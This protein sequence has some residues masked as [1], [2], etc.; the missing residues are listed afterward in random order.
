M[1]QRNL[2]TK[3]QSPDQRLYDINMANDINLSLQI[4]NPDLQKPEVLKSADYQ[5]DINSDHAIKAI[6]YGTLRHDYPLMLMEFER[7]VPEDDDVVIEILYC[8][9]CHTDWHVIRNEWKNSKYPIIVGHEI[10]GTVVKIG[11]NVSRFQIGDSVALGP[12][13]NSCRQCSQC[14]TG[15]EQY[16]LND[17]TETYNMPDRKLGE[18]KPTGPVTQ[19][20]YSNIIVANQ[21]YLLK[22]PNSAPLDR[23]APLACAGA[24]VYTPL[25]YSG[26][27]PGNRIGIAGCGGL[28]HFGIKLAKAL[29]FE[30]IALTRTKEKLN[31]L[32]RLGADQALYVPD[33]DSLQAYE[34]TFDLIIDTIPFNH[35]L[36]PYLN[37]IKPHGT[38]WIVGSFFTM[39]TDFDITNR[40]GRIIRGSSTAGISDTQELVDL[41]INNDIYPEIQVIKIKDINATHEKLVTSQV[42]Y[43]YVIDMSTIYSTMIE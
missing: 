28:G 30:V 31:D 3:R 16:C 7:R 8:G 5:L 40:K 32:K 42:R 14:N 36:M 35:D 6:G 10:V 26:V 15:F 27:Q 43:R 21:Y 9:V 11:S 12:N 18:I 2:N 22:I 41:C 13:Y 1:T 24:T 4:P 20:G 23:V 38:L 34:M 25:K 37:L 17:V 19:G 29:G 33:A 39:A